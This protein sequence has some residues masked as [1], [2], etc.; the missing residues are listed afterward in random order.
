MHEQSNAEV[1]YDHT[2]LAWMWESAPN[3]RGAHLMDVTHG[4]G[5]IHPHM[6]NKRSLNWM[7]AIFT[8]YHHGHKLDACGKAMFIPSIGG[9]WQELPQIFEWDELILTEVSGAADLI[10]GAQLAGVTIRSMHDVQ[11]VLNAKRPAAFEHN[12]DRDSFLKLELPLAFISR[13]VG[14]LHV[15]GERDLG[16]TEWA[17][18]QFVNPLYVTERNVLLDFRAGWHDGIVIDKLRPCDVFSLHECEDLT[19]YMQPAAIKCL[20]KLARLPKRLP[21]IF[22]TNERDVWPKDPMGDPRGQT[23]CAA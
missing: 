1:P 23:N 18:A 16:K 12:F 3:I 9:P 5:R 11:L 20:Y 19:D 22:V 7:K 15:Y 8:R 13:S 21:K 14:T 2:H 6:V 10:E 4:G 17:L